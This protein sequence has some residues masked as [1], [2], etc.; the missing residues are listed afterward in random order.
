MYC[1]TYKSLTQEDLRAHEE[2]RELER[3]A[4]PISE[5]LASTDVSASPRAEKPAEHL[6][7]PP[8]QHLLPPAVL[9]LISES[10][11]RREY[12]YPNFESGG[13]LAKDVDQKQDIVS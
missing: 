9:P 6:E 3:N 11:P 4:R 13:V 1:E 8:T 5:F 12:V 2:Q 10:K 7:S